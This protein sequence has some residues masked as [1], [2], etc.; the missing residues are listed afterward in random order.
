MNKD[1]S[2]LSSWDSLSAGLTRV[3]L[4]LVKTNSETAWPCRHREKTIGADLNRHPLTVPSLTRC[5]PRRG[6]AMLQSP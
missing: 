5:R 1:Q 2:H 4:A 6:C 3:C